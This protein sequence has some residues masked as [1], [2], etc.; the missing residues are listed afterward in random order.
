M[1]IALWIVQVLLALAFLGA[2]GFKVFAYDKYK[3]MADKNGPSGLSR[4]LVMF[5][6]IAELFGAIGV[7]LPMAA[8]IAPWLSPLAAAGLAIAMLLGVFYHLRRHESAASPGVLLLLALFVTVG[9]FS[10]WT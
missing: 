1:N 10:N 9:R 7:V 8:G 6:G 4:G 5:I 3:A 2:G